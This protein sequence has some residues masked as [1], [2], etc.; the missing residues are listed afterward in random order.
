MASTN[1]YIVNSPTSGTHYF[2]DTSIQVVP[3]ASSNFQCQV[4]A[5]S[6]ANGTGSLVAVSSLSVFA[7]NITTSA[8]VG[9]VSVGSANTVQNNL[10]LGNG[11][12]VYTA[13]G[14]Y[15]GSGVGSLTLQVT[16][17]SGHPYSQVYM[18]R[19]GA[20]VLVPAGYVRRTGAWVQSSVYLRRSGAWV[21]IA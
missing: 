11:S 13:G 4:H 3:D 15:S 14:Y 21:Q 8:E 12:D 1:L 6:G 7:K 2:G 16:S 5:W 10:S 17:Y 19:S 9:S 18:R 20:W